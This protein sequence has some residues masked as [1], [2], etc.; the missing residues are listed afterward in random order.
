MNILLVDYYY[1]H[2]NFGDDILFKNSVAFLRTTFPE[3]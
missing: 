1:R 2:G 3:A